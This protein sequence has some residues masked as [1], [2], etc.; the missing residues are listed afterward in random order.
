MQRTTDMVVKQT[1]CHFDFIIKQK[2]FQCSNKSFQTAIRNQQRKGPRSDHLVLVHVLKSVPLKEMKSEIFLLL[3]GC[4]FSHFVT[5]WLQ[6][7]FW[8]SHMED[9]LFYLGN[10]LMLTAQFSGAMHLWHN[11]INVCGI[12]ACKKSSAHKKKLL[13]SPG[14]KNT[15]GGTITSLY[16]WQNS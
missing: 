14:G 5:L 6:L 12:S 10:V 2:M 8:R 11:E 9:Q 3:M 15:T 16:V 1:L 7:P 13:L 4:L